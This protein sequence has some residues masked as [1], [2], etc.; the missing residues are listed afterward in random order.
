MLN[1]NHPRSI[2]VFGGTESGSS[3][4]FL[5]AA[6]NIGKQIAQCGHQLIFGGG[7]AGIMGALANSAMKAGGKVIS[8]IPRAMSDRDDNLKSVSEMIITG[9]MH[10]RKLKM[11]SLADAFITLPGG[12]GT[13][14]ET[15]EVLSWLNLGIIEQKPLFLINIDCYWT[16]LQHMLEFMVSSKFM[17]KH[18]LKL[19]NFV[20]NSEGILTKIDEILSAFKLSNENK[21]DIEVEMEKRYQNLP[22]F[23]C[24]YE[25]QKIAAKEGFDWTNQ[26]Q[27]FQKLQEEIQELLEVINETDNKV[28][29]SEEYGD[30]LFALINLSRHLGIDYEDSLNNAITKFMKRYQ[31]M[32][33]L[34]SKAGINFANLE[35]SEML[36]WWNEVKSD[37]C[38]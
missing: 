14:D 18:V 1:I 10:D 6:E 8:I 28:R 20:S 38:L 19:A 3:P 15:I 16:H 26:L 37:N 22:S 13:L 12:M 27:T 4:L 29:I 2:C 34:T 32:K 31:H 21:I 7:N 24:A 17:N 23:S 30:T 33:R 35:L 9:S 11:Y 36:V 5:E 25:I